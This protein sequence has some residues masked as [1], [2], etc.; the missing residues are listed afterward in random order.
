MGELYFYMGKWDAAVE[1]SKEA[2][3]LKPDFGSDNR[4]SYI[5]AM[6]ED[7]PAALLSIDQ[8]I[9]AAPSNGLKAWGSQLKAVY[10]HLLGKTAAAFADLAK[11]RGY[12]LADNDFI[13]ADNIYRS[14]IWTSYDLG[15]YDQFLQYAK[16]RFDFRAEHKVRSGPLNDVLLIFYRGLADIR[17]NR[18]DAAKTQLAKI[19]AARVKIADPEK[20]TLDM[21]YYH[22]LS[23]IL[24]A[25]GEPEKTMEA[26]KKIGGPS[27]EIGAI[28]T[29]IMNGVP[30]TFDIP[31]RAYQKKGEIDKA[32]AEYEKLISPDPLARGFR[33]IHPLSR[34]RL[35]KLYE[36]KGLQSKALEQYEK[37][38]LIWKEAD[39]DFR[40]AQELKQRLAALKAG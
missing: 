29:L 19:E 15:R 8:F 6:R 30:S 38:T 1:K 7:Y 2:I 11:A 26:Y 22:L 4:I 24:A 17:Q 39:A 14:L 37:L 16:E 13:N 27:V 10:D 20:P 33:L 40:E 34:F 23:E 18:P 35:A 21:A 36:Q 9:A 3:R 28:F 31:A 5:Q 32:I 25:Q 12:A